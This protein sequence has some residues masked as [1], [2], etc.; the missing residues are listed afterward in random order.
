[1]ATPCDTGFQQVTAGVIHG[2]HL[3]CIFHSAN[4]SLSH[5]LPWHP[6]Q[7]RLSDMKICAPL[8]TLQTLLY[9]HLSLGSY[10]CK[11][12]LPTQA[13]LGSGKFHLARSGHV[14]PQSEHRCTAASQHDDESRLR[15]SA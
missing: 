9:H 2:C 10:T 1:M 5:S 12:S 4:A 14:S 3:L 13:I 15:G 6:S 7:F 8:G 11:S